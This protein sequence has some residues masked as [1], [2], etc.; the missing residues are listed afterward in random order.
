MRFSDRLYMRLSKISWRFSQYTSKVIHV[1]GHGQVLQVP[2]YKG[3]GRDNVYYH[4]EKLYPF[5]KPLTSYKNGVFVDVGANTG[6][7]LT[8]LLFANREIPYI[9]FEPSLPCCSYIESLIQANKLTNHTIYPYGLSDSFTSLNLMFNGECDVCASTTPSFRP[10]NFFSYKKKILLVSGDDVLL[11]L[12]NEPIGIV[13]IDVEGSELEVIKGIIGTIN[14]YRPAILF[15][16]LPYKHLEGESQIF[17]GISNDER[18]TIIA[19]RKQRIA[20]LEEKLAEL[21]YIYY[22]LEDDGKLLPVQSIDSDG[23]KQT[24]EMN[25][26]A[27]CADEKEQFQNHF[28]AMRA[29]SIGVA[30]VVRP[31]KVV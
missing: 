23:P 27:I 15:E 17:K 16:V 22:R 24:H 5:I 29:S 25:F 20:A 19:T 8:V 11:K 26:L 6:Q 28:K 10:D 13:K 31:G 1:Q 9:G 30:S 7:M 12:T 2:V 14:R 4:N 3:I 21:N 18:A